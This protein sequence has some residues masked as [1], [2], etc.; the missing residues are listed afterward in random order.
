MPNVPAE[1]TAAASPHLPTRRMSP[2]QS[3]VIALALLALIPAACE[4][5]PMPPHVIPPNTAA[6]TDAGSAPAETCAAKAAGPR[7]TSY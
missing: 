6:S 2:R 3:G 7:A 4:R 1:T 5:R